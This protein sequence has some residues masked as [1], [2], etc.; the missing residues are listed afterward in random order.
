MILTIETNKRSFIKAIVALCKTSGILSYKLEDKPPVYNPEIVAAV[1]RDRSGNREGYLT[2]KTP[3]EM[4]QHFGTE[5]KDF[6]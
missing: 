1:E 4:Y 3:E 2:F 5:A 6:E